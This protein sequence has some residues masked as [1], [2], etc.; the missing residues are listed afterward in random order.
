[1]LRSLV[2]VRAVT[3]PEDPNMF[4]SQTRPKY[5]EQAPAPTTVWT[6]YSRPPEAV[7]ISGVVT[8][9]LLLATNQRE[10]VRM[11]K[12]YVADRIHRS[13]RHPTLVQTAVIGPQNPPRKTSSLSL[14]PALQTLDA[15][16][17]PSTHGITLL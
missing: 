6:K 3:E 16:G 8:D 1:M 11:S 17:W 13:L 4:H 9:L 2:V 5:D 15:R 14:S 12:K 7:P 10:R